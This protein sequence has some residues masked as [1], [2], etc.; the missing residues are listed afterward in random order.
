MIIY[1]SFEPHCN[2]AGAL[3]LLPICGNSRSKLWLIFLLCMLSRVE[4]APWTNDQ[5]VRNSVPLRVEAK[6]PGLTLDWCHFAA[7]RV[8]M[9]F[10][11]RQKQFDSGSFFFLLGA[12]Q[13][14]TVV[15]LMMRWWI[16]NDSSSAYYC[17]YHVSVGI[18]RSDNH[19]IDNVDN[20][21]VKMKTVLE[22]VAMVNVSFIVEI[23]ANIWR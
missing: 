3:S 22:T 8:F 1:L 5:Q 18:Q 15:M 23:T 2:L 20:K 12:A 14:A 13:M 9:A 16:Y 6:G 10:S 4:P 19:I 11:F 17:L 21:G 7:N